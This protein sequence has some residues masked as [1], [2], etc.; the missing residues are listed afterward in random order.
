MSA[1]P[2]A[3]LLRWSRAGATA[4]LALVLATGA[5]VSA[6]GLLPSLP[7]LVS[8]AGVAVLGCAVVLDRPASTVR[9]VALVA[10]VQSAGHVVLTAL[11]GHRGGP[12]AATPGRSAAAEASTVIVAPPRVDAAGRRTGSLHDLVAAGTG[13]AAPGS[14]TG[15]LTPHWAGHLIDD[16]SGPYAAMVL[17]HLLAAVLLGWWLATGERA[18]WTLLSLGAVEARRGR[19]RLA[20]LARG[21]DKPCVGP[22][23]GVEY[24]AAVPVGD[25]AAPPMA[26]TCQPVTRRGP[27]GLAA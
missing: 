19:A 18:L 17:A 24:A 22:A 25:Q 16:L 23:A 9:V 3:P 10:G 27:P 7:V 15:S 13:A 6:G 8:L 20:A 1:E 5:H 4:G 14:G 11:A 2:V 21:L 12:T 26:V